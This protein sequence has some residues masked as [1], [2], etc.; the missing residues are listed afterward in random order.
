MKQKARRGPKAQPASIHARRAPRFRRARAGQLSLLAIA[1]LIMATAVACGGSGAKTPSATSTASVAAVA[2]VTT[3]A[4]PPATAT[5]EP[6]ASPTV[7]AVPAGLYPREISTGTAVDAT[8]RAVVGQDTTALAQLFGYTKKACSSSRG[9]GAPP[10]NGAADGTL[11]DAVFSRQ[12]E[13]GWVSSADINAASL[14][15]FV[16]PQQFLYGVLKVDPQSSHTLP[17]GI[18]GASFLLVFQTPVPAL[19]GGSE[20]GREF[21]VTADGHIVFFGIG[22]GDQAPAMFASHTSFAVTGTLLGPR[23]GAPGSPT[24]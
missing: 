16:Q 20:P 3:L 11:V 19:H 5:P 22:C 7:V 23:E 4:P 17:G 24:P 9:T 18:D 14:S 6:G 21:G 12:C 1:A 15:P 13:G 2:T 10:C 8:I